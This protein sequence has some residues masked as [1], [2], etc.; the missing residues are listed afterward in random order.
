LKQADGYD[1]L[2]LLDISGRVLFRKTIPADSMLTFD[3]GAHPAGAYFLRISGGQK[4]VFTLK[5]LK[6]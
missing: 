4:P 1:Q 5:V 3:M 6:L 2:E